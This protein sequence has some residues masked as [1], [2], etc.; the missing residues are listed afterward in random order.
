MC[1]DRQLDLR[2]RPDCFPV[3]LELGDGLADQADI[4]IESDRRDV[5]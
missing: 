3:T 5:A 2:L 1:V 4:E